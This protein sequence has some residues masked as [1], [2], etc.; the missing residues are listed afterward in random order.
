VRG[1]DA[2]AR[3]LA[4]RL[5][6]NNS[7]DYGRSFADIFTTAGYDFYKIDPALFAPAEVWVGNLDSGNTWHAGALNMPLLTSLWLK[8]A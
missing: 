4:R 5:P 2:A 1:D 8:E 7:R 6:S 3:D